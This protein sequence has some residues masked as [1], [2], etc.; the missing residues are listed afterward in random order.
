[1]N[2]SPSHRVVSRLLDRS[3]P[4]AIDDFIFKEKATATNENDVSSSCLAKSKSSSVHQKSA[5][6]SLPAD[7]TS[8]I[9]S[10][11]LPHELFDISVISK[12]GND[13]FNCDLLWKIKFQSRW[14]C[15]PDVSVPPARSDRVGG[16]GEGALCDAS[17]HGSA[18]KSELCGEQSPN[19]NNG[20]NRSTSGFW[21]RCF[22]NAHGNPH[23][24]WVRHWNC[25]TPE[26]VTTVVGRTVVPSDYVEGFCCI[27]D[28]QNGILFRQQDV[29]QNQ[30]SSTLQH[31]QQ[32]VQEE[33]LIEFQNQ[34]DS[35]TMRCCPTCR[36]HPMLH[37]S[38]YS[39]VIE[40]VEAELNYAKQ[41]DND[42][43]MKHHQQQTIDDPVEAAEIVA[44]AHALLC[45]S[46]SKTITRADLQS[47]VSKAIH[48]STQYSV[49]KWC[50]N[51]HHDDGQS[52]LLDRY[53]RNLNQRGEEVEGTPVKHPR[54]VQKEA[55]RAFECA[56]TYNRKIET[57]QYQ[58]S[59]IQFLSD[60]LFFN[61]HSRTS[62]FDQSM[63]KRELGHDVG[64]SSSISELGP[65]FETSHHTWHVIR[66]SN[67]DF[68]RPLTFRAYIQCPDVFTVYPSKGYLQ[69]G[70]TVYLTLG[71]RMKGS[72]R[73]E[74]FERVDV[75]REEVDAEMARLYATE[76]HLPFVPFAIRYMWATPIPMKPT[77]YASRPS[78][79]NR[80]PFGPAT[81]QNQ[82]LQGSVL[83]HL[84]ENVKSEAD[85]RTIYISAH[86]NNSYGFEEFQHATLSPFHIDIGSNHATTLT[87]NMPQILQ[88]SI[89][90]F[91]VIENLNKETELSI[92]GDLYRTEKKCV[93]CKRDW[94]PQSEL[95]GRA[96]LLRRLECQ[97]HNLL[98]EQE[99]ANFDRSL[100]MIPSLLNRVLSC[101]DEDDVDNAT[102]KIGGL[103][104]ICQLLYCTHR[105]HIIPMKSKRLVSEEQREWYAHCERY[106]DDTYADIQRILVE[107][108]SRDISEGFTMDKQLWRGRGIYKTNKCTE[109]IEEE[110]EATNAL[111]YKP[112]PKFLHKF[113][114]LDYN[115]FG[116]VTLG[117]QDDPNHAT[118]VSM[119]TDMF[120]NDALKSFAIACLM[121]G[122]P[123]VLIGHGVYDRVKAPGSIIRCPS[124]PVVTYFRQ[125]RSERQNKLQKVMRILEKWSSTAAACGW[126]PTNS[127]PSLEQKHFGFK[128]INFEFNEQDPDGLNLIVFGQQN[129]QINFQTTM[130]H[131]ISNVPLPGQ[132]K[133]FLLSSPQFEETAIFCASI[134]MLYTKVQPY[135]NILHPS[136]EEEDI[137][138]QEVESRN[139]QNHVPIDRNQQNDAVLALNVIM[140]IAMH[141]GWTIDDDYR[142]GF[143]L[144]DRRLLISAQWF[145]NT[146]ITASLLASLLSRKIM[147]I[148]PFPANRAMQV[149][150]WSSYPMKQFAVQAASSQDR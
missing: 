133:L 61:V 122:N 126:K 40:A 98:R 27:D 7:T 1:M 51:L 135:A 110:R 89:E 71:V 140:L 137:Q 57:S 66:L 50:R 69:P 120:Q 29:L 83:D 72:M 20:T 81:Q 44:S 121:M 100:R 15:L 62:S 82:T 144:V 56:S 16:G 60:A 103:N 42:G 76:G 22:M 127:S 149:G 105:E 101:E 23:D 123:K 86:I 125:I 48:Y 63:M 30:G 134:N 111:M 74:A 139:Q 97:K 90:L 94:G 52:S 128:G 115:P 73:N 45:N 78:F 114:S 2:A 79:N 43:T 39:N 21:K 19:K 85:V 87:T 148:N 70:E 3:P 59:G 147:L 129:Y 93:V 4:P 106:I 150:F 109:M 112:E 95:L 54:S 55:N 24:L 104:R 91:K 67:P 117:V 68:I 65:N 49:A 113:K 132:G 84:W 31:Q 141:L 143:L 99:R 145:A 28:E 108:S 36:Y 41:R 116:M 107:R 18:D 35:P 12:S 138:N 131:Y 32:G 124:L 6:E 102:S 34:F 10:F 53:N 64:D 13:M 92:S 38:G 80:P 77:D 46:P 26:D 8:H 58:S 96:Y 47:S 118:T 11:L 9:L 88:K 136:M 14:N 142:G 17:F 146:I 25:V 5:I 33:E 75:E 130:A 119:H 37:P